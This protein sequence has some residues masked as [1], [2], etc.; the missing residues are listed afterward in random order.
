VTTV[1]VF[2][3]WAVV[4]ALGLVGVPFAEVVFGRLPGSGRIFA[5]PLGLLVVAYPG[6]LLA[7]AHVAPYGRAIALI[8]LAAAAAAAAILRR[9]RRRGRAAPEHRSIWMVGEALFAVTFF[10][11][12]LMRSFAPDVWQTE[13]PMDMALINVINR[14]GFFPPHDPWLAG[15]HVNYY[16]LGH[17]LV[18]FLIKLT[19][20]DPAVGFNLGVALFYAL[21][22]AAVFGVAATLHATLRR[23]E[24]QRRPPSVAVGLAATALAMTVGNLA[25]VTQLLHHAH[26]LGTYDWWSPSRVIP[27]T[28]NEFPFF[29]FLLG[30]LHAHVMA[31]PF[32]LLAVAYALQVATRG[33]AVR[34]GRSLAAVAVELVLASMVLGSLYAINSFDFP[35]AS[36]ILLASLLVWGLD[37]A[38]RGR[39]ALGWAGGILVIAVFLF[40]PFWL[41][42]SPPTHGIALVRDHARFTRFASE[43]LLIFGIPLWSVPVVFAGRWHPRFRHLVWGGSVALFVLVL[44]A[45]PR[46]AGLAAALTLA[47][48]A[49]F[50][51]L[52]SGR[53]TPPQRFLWLLLATALGLVAIAELVY[54]R[55]AFDGT[56]SFRFNTVFKT[57]YQAWFLFAIVAAVGAFWAADWLGRRA[58]RLWLV[59]F[60]ALVVLGLAY[61]IFASYSRAGAFNGTPTLD[62]VRWLERD[63]PGDAAAIEWLRRSAVGSPAVLETFGRDFDPDGRGRVSTF[64][65]LPSVMEWPGHEVQWGHDP[66]TRASDVSIIYRTLN[67]EV[68]QRVLRR[69][70]VRYV[71]V[72]SLERRDYTPIELLKFSR[73]GT[74]VFRSR[75]TL[76]YRL[77]P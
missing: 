46:L 52:G 39:A 2:F 35:T 45:P 30:D 7:S 48:A 50:A 38:R 6:W 18:A 77:A 37:G 69:Y 26:Q 63:S 3:F 34:A 60:A 20:I 11:W 14:G 15:S 31:T 22:S 54:I 49:A 47:A 27:G 68:A 13:K 59:G 12:L 61:P 51:T 4:S 25:G 72:G 64:T 67:L 21:T 73:V 8:S 36:A 66:G 41:R 32:A 74:V 1:Q 70:H 58:Y 19:G 40:L 5:R 76:V 24:G 62:G 23:P 55:D 57:G 71:F 43:N 75:A 65:G 29:S 28:A 9:R 33:P 56:S 16:Y 10:G 53:I 17:Y 42:F 44:L